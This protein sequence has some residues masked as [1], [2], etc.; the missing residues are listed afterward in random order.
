MVAG[1]RETSQSLLKG[2]NS[3]DG[4]NAPKYIR[5]PYGE[6]GLD[7]DLSSNL[8]SE[9][10]ERTVIRGWITQWLNWVH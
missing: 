7:G 4:Q 6:K 3:G 5:F 2:E 1:R 8:E 10:L 9:L